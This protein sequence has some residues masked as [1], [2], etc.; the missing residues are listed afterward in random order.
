[1]TQRGEFSAANLS[2]AARRA[3]YSKGV[4]TAKTW[5]ALAHVTCQSEHDANWDI[6]VAEV[7]GTN[8]TQATIT[9]GDIFVYSIVL[10]YTPMARV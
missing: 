10:D 6:P 8:G 9:A 4:K 2:K 7:F 5:N 3:A 1:M